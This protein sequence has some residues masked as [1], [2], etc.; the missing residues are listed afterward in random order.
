MKVFVDVIIPVHNAEAT[1]EDTINSAMRQSIPSTLLFDD[2]NTT[3]TNDAKNEKYH[4]DG[5][6]RCMLN[7]TEID[8]AVCCYDDGSTDKSFQL[9]E[10]LQKKYEDMNNSD[11]EDTDDEISLMTGSTRSNNRNHTTVKSNRIFT[12]LYIGQSQDGIGRGAGHAR[13]RCSKLRTTPSVTRTTVTTSRFICLLDSDDIMHQ[14]RVAEQVSVMLKLS[15]QER[16]STILG[17]TFERIP[18]DSTWHYTNWANNLTDERLILERFREVT[19]LQPTW[20]M[21]RSRFDVLGGY[22]EAPY[23]LNTTPSISRPNDDGIKDHDDNHHSDENCELTNNT[24]NQVYKL[25]HPIHDDPQ[26]L[27]LAEDLRFFHAHLLYKSN[28]DNNTDNDEHQEKLYNNGGK[29]KLVRTNEPLL[30]YRHRLGQSQSSSTSRKLLL[31]LRTKAF[32]DTILRPMVVNNNNNNNNHK[33]DSNIQNTNIWLYDKETKKGGFVIWGAGRDGKEFFKSLPDEMKHHVRCFVDVDEKKI[34]SGHY[35]VP[36]SS[37]IINNNVDDYKGGDKKNNKNDNNTIKVPIVHFS[38]LTR[39]DTKRNILMNEWMYPNETTMKQ[40]D[41]GRITKDNPCH[42][43]LT[44]RIKIITHD[45]NKSGNNTD[46][47][48][49]IP[50]RKL[51][52]IPS[53]DKDNLTLIEN[54]L[55]DLP[56]LVCVAMYRSNGVLEKNVESIGRKEGLDLWHF[57]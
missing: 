40:E 2:T 6:D 38:L 12:K 37:M 32:V 50:K 9:M 15:P 7:D 26:S 17:C 35:I 4:L 52:T 24:V 54:E 14:H 48:T 23:P 43:P 46:G 16:L 34:N 31:H 11:N 5:Y 27:R 39:D 28:V 10:E 18:Q 47:I 1:I 8:V 3:V 55:K 20:M 13:N 49:T 42:P 29:L 45:G 41:M 44:K 57:S 53:K 36:L 56:V 22:I 21:D 19:V 30:K 25:I 51:H 33:N